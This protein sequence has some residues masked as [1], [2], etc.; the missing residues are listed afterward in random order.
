VARVRETGVLRLYPGWGRTLETFQE[1]HPDAAGLAHL[2]GAGDFD[3][4]GTPD[5]LAVDTATGKLVRYPIRAT[6]LGTP[7]PVAGDLGGVALL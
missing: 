7:V 4:D 5:L 1:I 2:T 3:R 6:G